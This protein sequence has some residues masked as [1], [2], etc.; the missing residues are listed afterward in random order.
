M[1]RDEYGWFQEKRPFKKRDC[2]RHRPYLTH[3]L[4]VAQ[5]TQY[6]IGGSVA[7]FLFSGRPT[8]VE[9]LE[10]IRAGDE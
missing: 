7:L 10:R 8:L 3:E 5:I 1:V 2:R 6:V 4:S 9:A